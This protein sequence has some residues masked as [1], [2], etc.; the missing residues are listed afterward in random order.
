MSNKRFSLALHGGAGAK[1]GHDY[2]VE[3]AH[4]RG[5]IEAARERLAAGASALD[6]AVE[7][8]VGLEASGL[9]IAG[10]GASPNAAGE[11]ELDASLMDGASLKA[12]SVAALQGFKSPILAARAVMEQTP[13]VMLAGQG[14]I[15]F[16][17]AQGLETVEDPQSWFT[18]AGAFE[19][20]HPPEALP[21]GTV[22][23]VVRDNEGRL[24]A[25]TSTAGVFGKLPGRVGDSPIIGAGAWADGHAAVSCTGQGEYFIRTAVGVQIAHR[26][27]FGG[28]SLEAAA[29]AA[30]QGVA[31]LGG[32]GGLVSVD[33]EGN[34]AMPFASSG[35]KRA[36]L[37]LDGTVISEAF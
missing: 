7:T 25:A 34:V 30:I 20:N 21:T 33:R 11:Y 6:V 12:G 31:D 9:Y 16:A 36:A 19:D 35:L 22:G 27:R 17:R 1:P 13:H 37:L 10:K 23:C 8:V 14:A 29:Q 3:I 18:Q 28:E 32:H 24:A 26:M 15:D 4:M 5:L 2:S